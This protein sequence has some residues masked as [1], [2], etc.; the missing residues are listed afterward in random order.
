MKRLASA[1]E[2]LFFVAF[3]VVA[4]LH[5]QVGR[6]TLLSR[7]VVHLQCVDSSAV[8]KEFASFG[9]YSSS[10]LGRVLRLLLHSNAAWRV[11]TPTH[12]AR[13]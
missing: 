3:A 11:V 10:L 9:I 7:V 6:T 8:R 5:S 13:Y 12:N 2:L 1:G 4:H